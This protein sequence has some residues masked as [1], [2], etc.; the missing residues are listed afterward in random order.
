MIDLRSELLNSR[1][2]V[3]SEVAEVQIETQAGTQTVYVCRPPLSARDRAAKLNQ[4]DDFEFVRLQALCIVKCLRE[5][6]MGDLVFDDAD[7]G[8][9]ASG[10]CGDWFDDLAQICL[11]VTMPSTE[12]EDGGN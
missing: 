2:T 7:V 9:L 8:E 5:E 3:G 1:K 12:G 4:G 11:E 10:A 6:P